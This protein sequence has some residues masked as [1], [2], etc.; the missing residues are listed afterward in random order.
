MDLINWLR[1][2]V[3]S[4]L[5]GGSFFFVEVA[6]TGLPLFTIV[7]LRVFLGAALLFLFILFA[8][9]AVP[10]DRRIWRDFFVMGLLNNVVPFCLI[11]G[12][13]RYISGGFASLLNG[14]TPFFTVVAAHFFTSDEKLNGGKVIGVILG[15]TGV[16]FLTGFETLSGGSHE[17]RGILSFLGAA[18]SYALAALWGRRFKSYELDPVVPAAGQ[19]ACSSLLL[20][21]VLLITDRPW[22]LERPD[23][24]VWAA[25]G[26]IALLSTALAYVL[27]FK[28]LASAG[29]THVLLV[30]FLIPI[31]AILLGVFLL[32][33]SFKIEYL[34]GIF[35]IGAGLAFIDGGFLRWIGRRRY[36]RSTGEL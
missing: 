2:F 17:I 19:L 21:P 27:Y 31:T 30:T 8:G 11:V 25:V 1:L 9:K 32:A 29:A 4:V 34:P 33:E 26:G 36:V 13:Q 12:G 14:T 24:A 7:F 3:L 5:W 16:A 18:V 23:G 35:M 22:M 28:I 10:K 6:L 15:I 20:L